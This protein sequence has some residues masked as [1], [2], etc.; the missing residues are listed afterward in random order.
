MV[1]HHNQLTNSESFKSLEE[2]SQTGLNDYTILGKTVELTDVQKRVI[3]LLYQRDKS[4]KEISKEGGWIQ[5]ILSKYINR[6]LSEREKCGR[7]RCPRN[8]YNHSLEWF[9]KQNLFRLSLKS[10]NQEPQCS[11]ESYIWATTHILF[12]MSSYS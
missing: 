8:R 9:I 1:K 5:Y 6:K 10:A 7:K 3:E 11:E 12:F 4:Q 2:V